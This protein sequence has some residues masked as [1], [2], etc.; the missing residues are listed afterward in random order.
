MLRGQFALQSVAANRIIEPYLLRAETGCR[1][2]VQ[3]LVHHLPHL[4]E[5]PL[6]AILFPGLCGGANRGLLIPGLYQFQLFLFGYV[7]HRVTFVLTCEQPTSG[8]RTLVVPV[9]YF[10]FRTYWHGRHIDTP[11]GME[12]NLYN[13]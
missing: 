6:R 10:L 11:D 8:G 5:P 1:L 12:E 7:H 13:L 9:N 2:P 3:S 4:F